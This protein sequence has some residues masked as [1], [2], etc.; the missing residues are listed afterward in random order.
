[1]TLARAVLKLVPT[2]PAIS[3]SMFGKDR[4]RMMLARA[5]LKLVPAL[6]AKTGLCLGRIANSTKIPVCQYRL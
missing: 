5:V 2:L 3:N 6:R 4:P 1:M